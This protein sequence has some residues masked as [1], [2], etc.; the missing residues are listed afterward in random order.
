MKAAQI[1]RDIETL[2]REKLDYTGELEPKQRLVEDLQLDSL[3]LL[4]LATEVEDHFLVCLDESDEAVL[5]TVGDLV[6][7]V[8][9][10]LAE[11]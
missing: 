7:M 5:E 2:A 9:R 3:R 8:E 6:Q 1:L 10:K 4:T 11:A